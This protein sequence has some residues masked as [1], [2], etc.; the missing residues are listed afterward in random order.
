MPNNLKEYKQKI[1]ELVGKTIEEYKTTGDTASQSDLVATYKKC[2]V[3]LGS[4]SEHEYFVDLMSSAV[5]LY[6]YP[7]ASYMPDVFDLIMTISFLL[8]TLDD[9]TFRN[10][11]K[12]KH[13]FLDLL[14]AY[15]KEDNGTSPVTDRIL[16]VCHNYLK[17]FDDI[18]VKNR[19]QL[20]DKLQTTKTTI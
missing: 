5:A 11:R 12:Y 18:E 4:D 8:I 20:L 17:M 19:L 15:P 7:S 14:Y 6:L 10:F 9:G 3:E 13:R 1:Y 2:R 16:E